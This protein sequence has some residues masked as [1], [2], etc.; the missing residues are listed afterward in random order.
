[1][2]GVSDIHGNEEL[3]HGTGYVGRAHRD[4]KP[5]NILIDRKGNLKIIDF[6]MSSAIIDAEGAPKPLGGYCGSRAFMAPEVIDAKENLDSMYYG[7]KV[8]LFACGVILFAMVA[9][10][11]PFQ[12]SSHHDEKYVSII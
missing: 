5:K 10:I 4:L 3:F 9:G 6:G 12:D 8:D 1:M 2:Q 11:L 7:D